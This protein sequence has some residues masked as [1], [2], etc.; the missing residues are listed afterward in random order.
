MNFAGFDQSLATGAPAAGSGGDP[1]TGELQSASALLASPGRTA[2]QIGVES[3]VPQ[4]VARGYLA[5]L[6]LDE[7]SSPDLLLDFDAE[8]L[9]DARR[10]FTLDEGSAP[11]AL[12]RAQVN[13]WMRVLTEAVGPRAPSLLDPGFLA[14]R[15]APQLALTAPGAAGQGTA[16]HDHGRAGE[17]AA[18]TFQP[19][20]GLPLGPQP[21][22]EQQPP[23][24][25]PGFLP[26]FA[27]AAAA[28]PQPLILAAFAGSVAPPTRWM[29]DV[30]DHADPGVFAALTA[31]ELAAA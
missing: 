31:V 20:T 28:A 1:M 17:P 2:Y 15:A 6:G 21:R 19:G 3:G 30:L 22:L 4:A 25:L 9:V 14:S 23:T 16:M 8:D 5:E 13:S 18:L 24:G 10:A 7:G 11:S 12:H 26:A 27:K 29:G